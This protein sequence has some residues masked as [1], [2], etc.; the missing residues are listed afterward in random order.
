MK[1]GHTHTH[2]HRGKHKH[3]HNLKMKLVKHIIWSNKNIYLIS[4]EA[5]QVHRSDNP[6]KLFPPL[7]WWFIY[8]NNK[9]TPKLVKKQY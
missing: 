5:C 7:R 4:R 6:S 3:K 8:S 1:H 9:T 2:I